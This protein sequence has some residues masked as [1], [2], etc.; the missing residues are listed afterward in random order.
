MIYLFTAIASTWNFTQYFVTQELF[1]KDQRW[2]HGD[3]IKE[4]D[5]QKNKQDKRSL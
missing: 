2:Q 5:N 3:I 4:K 1:E